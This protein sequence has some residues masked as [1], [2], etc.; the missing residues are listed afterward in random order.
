MYLLTWNPTRWAWESFSQDLATLHERGALLMTW[1]CGRNKRIE[2]G[3]RLFLM[4]L[5]VD[6]KGIVGSAIA[7]GPPFEGPHWDPD[8]AADGDTGLF[9]EAQFDH[10]AAEPPILLAELLEPPFANGH[11]TP[12]ASATRIDDSAADALRQLWARRT[13]AGAEGGPDEVSGQPGL[14]EGA[15]RTVE[16]NAYERNAVARRR[17]IQHYGS[18]CFVCEMSFDRIYGDFAS[19]YM[20][21]HHVRPL[22]EVGEAYVV[23]PVYDLRPLCPNCHAAIHLSSPLMTPEELRA[24]IRQRAAAG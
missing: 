11:W 5:G 24:H 18:T 13:G 3:D 6:P 16:V 4:R 17:C 22:S 21:V 1:S 14:V 15:S 8:R 23:D 12:Q 2:P 7:A 9:V 20:H 19:G 10:L